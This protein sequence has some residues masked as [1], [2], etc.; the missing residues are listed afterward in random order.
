MYS[1]LYDSTSIVLINTWTEKPWGG[2]GYSPWGRKESDTTERLTLIL[3]PFISLFLFF[4]FSVPFCFLAVKYFP[5]LVFLLIA[6]LASFCYR[7]ETY[8]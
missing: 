5:C 4:F 1:S 6:T 7:M 3:L 8:L 2:G